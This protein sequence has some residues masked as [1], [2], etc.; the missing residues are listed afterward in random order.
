MS[1]KDETRPEGAWRNE[2]PNVT[3][4]LAGANKTMSMHSSAMIDNIH[5]ESA[6]AIAASMISSTEMMIRS[7]ANATSFLNDDSD[8]LIS[9]R[10][11]VSQF[12]LPFPP[13]LFGDY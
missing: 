5:E 2:D 10:V 1:V 6:W 3:Y 13:S 8:E 12:S 4:P 7:G 9:S 11:C